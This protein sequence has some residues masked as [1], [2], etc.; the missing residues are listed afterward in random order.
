MN[1]WGVGAF[2]VPHL[3]GSTCRNALDSAHCYDSLLISA[4]LRCIPCQ[5]IDL[6]IFKGREELETYLMRHKQRHHLVRAKGTSQTRQSREGQGT[7]GGFRD[8]AG[9]GDGTWTR[10]SC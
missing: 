1:T 8:W 2:N 7:W 5:A 4:W 6:L 9:S 3:T 10:C